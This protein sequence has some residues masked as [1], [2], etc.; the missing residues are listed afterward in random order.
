MVSSLYDVRDVCHASS[1]NFPVLVGT[2]DQ[3][4]SVP[5]YNWTEYFQDLGFEEIKNIKEFHHFRISAADPGYVTCTK[6]L[7]DDP[8]RICV[9]ENVDEVRTNL[10]DIVPPKGFSKKRKE[11]LFTDIREFCTEETKD[12]TAP[13]PDDY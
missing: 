13:D 8:V 1:C 9:V 12:I 3:K 6:N 7:D 2:H 5:T 10:P 11:Y 4:I